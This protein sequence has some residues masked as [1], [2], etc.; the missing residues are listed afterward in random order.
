MTNF[1]D[2]KY[3]LIQNNLNVTPQRIGVLDA[4]LNLNH[5]SAEQVLEYIRRNH[6]GV[7]PGTVYHIL[8]LFF[9]KGLVK[10][11]KTDKDIMRYDAIFEKHH[12]LYCSECDNIVDYFDEE[13]NTLLFNY[14]K[15]KQVP[16]FIIEDIKLQIV[17]KFSNQ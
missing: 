3:R 10:K 7:A 6:P 13:L 16:N 11:V 14:F 17:G 5:P 15:K 9:E 2:L 12:H 4:L 8:E 1:K